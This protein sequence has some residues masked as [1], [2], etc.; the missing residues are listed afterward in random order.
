MGAGADAQL[1]QATG[2]DGQQ[3][4]LKVYQLPTAQALAAAE[5]ECALSAQIDHPHLAQVRRVVCDGDQVAL[6][7]EFIDG[8]S[9]AEVVAVH[10]VLS[11]AQTATVLLPLAAALATAHERGVV[12]GDLAPPNVMVDRA[13]RPVLV[14]LGSARAEG[15]SPS[16]AANP[17]F[18]A[19]ELARSGAVTAAADMFSLGAL[20]NWCLT[21]KPAWA[22]EDFADVAVQA[23]VGQ[24]PDPGSGPLA[25]II[26]QMLAEEPAD[27]PGAAQVYLSAKKAVSASPIPVRIPPN[28]RH[29]IAE[30]QQHSSL[31]R[32]RELSTKV[33]PETVLAHLA[34]S[35]SEPDRHRRWPRL[36]AS[37]VVLVLLVAAALITM[38]W[39][40]T[41]G[42]PTAEQA[43]EQVAETLPGPT[44]HSGVPDP[45]T[46]TVAQ[47]APTTSASDD[48]GYLDIVTA[49][50]EAR[51]RALTSRDPVMLAQV[52]LPEASALRLD[53]EL[54]KQLRDADQQISDARHH[55]LGVRLLGV[56][57]DGQVRLAVVDA[58]PE[59]L[60]R[61]ADGQVLGRTPARGE[62]TTVLVLADTG[63][64]YRIAKVQR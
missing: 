8:Q 33:R 21:G 38:R 1:W 56:D 20:A 60:I 28:G 35:E 17:G 27:R 40:D 44:P 4:A 10:G 14:D 47:S 37:G 6:E 2:D 36:A 9:L 58:L 59:Y 53:E 50:D 26:R 15:E 49:L 19:P 11:A 25:R 48:P 43:A 3:V 54:I 64:G 57:N 39:V 31:D 22:A 18:I 23:T 45:A 51:A 62:A 30:A 52:Y 5:R 63:Q 13:G 55:V 7:M 29:R 24:W 12:H 34:E 16:V 41:G 61:G 46:G 32:I 42:V